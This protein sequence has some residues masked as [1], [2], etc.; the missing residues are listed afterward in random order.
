MKY[1]L[2]LLIPISLLSYVYS[3]N[4][5]V[6]SNITTSEKNPKSPKWAMNKKQF[7]TLLNENGMTFKMPKNFTEAKIE[8]NRDMPI[9]YAIKSKDGNFEVRYWIESIPKL[10]EMMKGVIGGKDPNSFYKSQVEIN[11]M[12]ISGHSHPIKLN[13]PPDE[14]VKYEFGGDKALYCKVVFHYKPTEYSKGF[15]R[16]IFWVVY[17]KDKA[18]IY[19]TFMSKDISHDKFI[20][21]LEDSFY[22]VQFKGAKVEG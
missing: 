2:T 7:L 3:Q 1:I 6:S 18:N 19:I 15:S 4:S 5:T 14:A 11:A 12:N 8:E 13:A 17:K 16:G 20:K 10:K 22:T 21:Y 9:N